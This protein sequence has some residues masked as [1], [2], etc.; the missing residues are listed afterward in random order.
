MEKEKQ[1]TFIRQL[2]NIRA[3]CKWPTRTKRE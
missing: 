3:T 1:K 2:K